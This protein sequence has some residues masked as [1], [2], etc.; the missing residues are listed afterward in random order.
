MLAAERAGRRPRRA[1]EGPAPG[2]ADPGSPAGADG[3]PGWLPSLGLGIAQAAALVPGVSRSGAVLTVGMLLG[4]RRE[5]AARFAFLLG[6][7][8]ILG[9][10]A[11]GTWDAVAGSAPPDGL[12]ALAVGAAASG[13]V[14]YVAIFGFLRY[15]ARH[16]LVP[17]ACY[18]IGLAA[19]VLLAR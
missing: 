13:L 18:R 19:A 8:A 6:V 1:P 12:A 7:P 14:G 2:A 17:F 10:G 4:L 11:K 9:A 3:P 15:V 16:T 5:P